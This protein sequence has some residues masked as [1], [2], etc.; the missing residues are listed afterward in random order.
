M[1]F[2]SRIVRGE[3]HKSLQ[4]FLIV[5]VLSLLLCIIYICLR[6][7]MF[8]EYCNVINEERNIF[9]KRPVYFHFKSMVHDH[10]SIYTSISCSHYCNIVGSVKSLRKLMF[11]IIVLNRPGEF[12]LPTPLSLGTLFFD[13]YYCPNALC[14]LCCAV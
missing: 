9:S 12:T 5:F 14:Q 11:V 3:S 4:L 6:N 7:R 8:N 1:F 13:Y 2:F 10:I